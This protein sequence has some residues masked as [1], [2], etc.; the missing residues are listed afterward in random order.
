M[1][2][3]VPMPIHETDSSGNPASGWLLYSYNNGTSTPKPLLSNTGTELTN[4]VVLDSVGRAIAF[5]D[6]GAY[7]L[8][9]H[10]ADDAEV[11][12]VDNINSSG[13]G[14][15]GLSTI[16]VSTIADLRAIDPAS[17]YGSA[18]VLCY[19]TL[20]SSMFMDTDGGG[21]WFAWDSSSSETDDYGTVIVPD[22]APVTGRWVRSFDGRYNV[23]YFGAQGDGVTIE[24]TAITRA[25]TA[26]AAKDAAILIPKG[27]FKIDADPGFTCPVEFDEYGV[28]KWTAEISPAITPVIRPDD[29]TQHFDTPEDYYPLISG[30]EQVRPSWFGAIGDGMEDDAV[31]LANM[32]GSVSGGARHNGIRVEMGQDRTYGLRT[33]LTIETDSMTINGNGS[34]FKTLEAITAITIQGSTNVSINRLTVDGDYTSSTGLYFALSGAVYNTGIAINDC[35]FQKCSKGVLIGS[36]DHY[37]VDATTQGTSFTRCL[38]V[39]NWTADIHCYDDW[40]WGIRFI[41][42]RFQ[43]LDIVTPANAWYVAKVEYGVLEFVNP[44]VETAADWVYL[45]SW[46]WWVQ[47]G[48]IKVTGGRTATAGLSIGHLRMAAQTSYPLNNF[49]RQSMGTVFEGHQFQGP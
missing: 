19:S 42:C 21:G 17:G 32:F 7:T 18:Y 14:S 20:H 9:M 37:A 38:F 16:V 2:T 1:A 45:E 13:F 35:S 41:D 49:Q 44:V 30:M 47:D 48:A 22:T 25:V 27:T 26:A 29:D 4:P 11:W 31:P 34:I 40:A 28:L 12:Q 36:G 10:D 24:T 33:G 43:H 5:L 6:A 8:K 39:S 3:L 23:R 46:I 15:T